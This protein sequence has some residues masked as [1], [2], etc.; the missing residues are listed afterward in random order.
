MRIVK[1]DG[2][3]RTLDEASALQTLRGRVGC[4]LC[5]FVANPS[6]TAG[7]AEPSPET[8]AGKEQV[9][10]EGYGESVYHFIGYERR[11]AVR[12]D[13]HSVVALARLNLRTSTES[14]TGTGQLF[15]REVE[16]L[17]FP[18]VRET[19]YRSA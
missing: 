11:R 9:L 3:P 17:E 6:A 8:H 19:L 13:L 2:R 7:G 18:E 12:R 16:E 14:C 1:R 10:V 5:R 15:F 4:V